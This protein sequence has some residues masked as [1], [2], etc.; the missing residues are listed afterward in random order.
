MDRKVAVSIIVPVYCVPEKYLYNCV[1]SLLNQTLKDIEI[2][3]V[4]DGSTDNSGQYCDKLS[5]DDKR[6]KVIHQKNRGLCG[7]RNTGVENAAGDWVAFVDGDD[8]VDSDTYECLYNSAIKN[9]VEVVMFGYVKEYPSKKIMMDYSKYFE[10]KKIYS[11]KE[12]IK[13]LQNMILNYNAN[14]AM[15]PTKFI[16]RDFLLKNNVFHDEVLRQGAE[17]IEFNIRLFSKL[18]KVLFID[19]KFYH[20]VYNDDSITTVHSEKNHFAVLNCFKKIKNEI[21]ENN[22][23][24]LNWF[25]NR[26]SHV[27]LTTAISGYFSDSNKTSYLNKRNGFKKYMEDDL[28][29]ETIKRKCYDN[30]GIV[31][32][33]TMFLIEKKLYF[34]VRIISKIRTKQKSY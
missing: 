17:G 21:D 7:A 11:T 16:K 1:N 4:D 32:K 18:N 22:I 23:E 12:E 31:R 8:W 20:Y 3:L 27:I 34:L 19:K 33:I 15:V 26:M 25:Y 5:K 28:V 10:N 24:M 9:D 2:I 29:Q 30:L 6:I 14:C 13:Y